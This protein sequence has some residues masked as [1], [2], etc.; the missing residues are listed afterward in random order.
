MSLRVIFFCL[1]VL[2]L[3]SCIVK[4]KTIESGEVGV[5]K[6]FG[7]VKDKQFQPGFK[8]FFA[9]TKMYLVNT[10]LNDFTIKHATRTL[11]GTLLTPEV[12]FFIRFREDKS[13]AIVSE[14]M[15]NFR[16][17]TVTP[18]RLYYLIENIFKSAIASAVSQTKSFEDNNINRKRLALAIK[19]EVLSNTIMDYFTIENVLI[20]SIF[21]DKVFKEVLNKEVQLNKELSNVELE[22]E[23]KRKKLVLD[24]LEAI[25]DSTYNSILKPTLDELILELERIKANKEIGTSSNAK[26]II[27]SD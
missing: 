18:V 12:S 3:S 20:N 27:I 4:W 26:T 16:G 9:G 2:L 17:K 10:Q 5:K 7:V 15:H 6:R 22:I 8:V 21:I 14:N 19:E 25:S 1:S 24:K 11:D 23:L 13:S